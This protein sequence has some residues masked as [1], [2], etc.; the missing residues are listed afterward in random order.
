M[1]A[2]AADAAAVELAGDGTCSRVR[3]TR[4]SADG[5]RIL[6]VVRYF[7]VGHGYVL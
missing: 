5:Y 3:E 4:E 2:L 7:S 1:S 6:W